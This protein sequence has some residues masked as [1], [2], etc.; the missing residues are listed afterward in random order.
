[1]DGGLNE[2]HC[3]HNDEA[4]LHIPKRS[5]SEKSSE[6][7]IFGKHWNETKMHEVQ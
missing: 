4:I 5:V 3:G 2:L 1:M 6:K 7:T